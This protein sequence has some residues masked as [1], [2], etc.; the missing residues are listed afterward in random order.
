MPLLFGPLNPR[1]AYTGT[2]CPHADLAFE[3]PDR[4]LHDALRS[5]E[6]RFDVTIVPG[7]L[8]LAGS[9]GLKCFFVGRTEN[10][11]RAVEVVVTR[12]LTDYRPGHDTAFELEASD[13]VEL[14]ELHG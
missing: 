4:T 7:A 3:V 13:I 14:V 12:G 5:Y 9:S 8:P 11:G 10:P 1:F 6:T 2:P